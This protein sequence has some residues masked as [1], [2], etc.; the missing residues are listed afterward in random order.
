MIPYDLRI[1]RLACRVSQLLALGAL[2]YF[3]VVGVVLIIVILA[4]AFAR[5]SGA[6]GELEPVGDE[7]AEGCVLVLRLF[8]FWL[9]LSSFW[10]FFVVLEEQLVVAILNLL[11]VDLLF[12]F[13]LLA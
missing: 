4:D 7:E 8:L 11:G 5:G 1:L 12:I 2:D 6:Q 10:L 13:W 3:V 9:L